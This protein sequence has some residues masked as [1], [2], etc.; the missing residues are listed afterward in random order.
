MAVTVERKGAADGVEQPDMPM[1]RGRH[2]RAGSD[3]VCSVHRGWGSPRGCVPSNDGRRAMI[4]GRDYRDV[5]R[6]LRAIA[7][8]QDVTTTD[9]RAWEAE[10]HQDVPQDAIE[11]LEGENR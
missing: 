3:H 7:N 6:E 8:S 9:W 4:R 2:A 5:L 11:Y 1:L 10:M